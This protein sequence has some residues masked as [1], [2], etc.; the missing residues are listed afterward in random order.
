MTFMVD[1]I[2]H[3]VKLAIL[4]VFFRH[5]SV[6]TSDQPFPEISPPGSSFNYKLPGDFV[7][8]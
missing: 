7:I 4:I 2:L 5:L 6:Y 8:G 3:N 1:S